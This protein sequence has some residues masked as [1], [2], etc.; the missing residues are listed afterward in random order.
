M[1]PKIIIAIVIIISI[2]CISI[3]IGVVYSISSEN[4]GNSEQSQSQENSQGNSNSTEFDCGSVYP[5]V[6]TYYDTKGE[7]KNKYVAAPFAHSKVDESTCDIKYTWSSAPGSSSK[8]T[9][10][11]KRRFKFKTG[12]NEVTSMD[13]HMSGITV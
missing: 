7:W 5:Q 11:D 12:T 10:I 1:N 4:P 3:I 6:K 9:G 2:I 13:G 8:G